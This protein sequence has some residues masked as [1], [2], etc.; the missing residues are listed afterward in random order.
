MDKLE[1]R[2]AEVD[3]IIVKLTNKIDSLE[4]QMAASVCK[5]KKKKKKKKNF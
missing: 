3:A 1:A 4:K 2:A 5:K